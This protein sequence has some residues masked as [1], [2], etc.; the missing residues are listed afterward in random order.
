MPHLAYLLLAFALDKPLFEVLVNT[1]PLGKRVDITYT[2]VN[3]S[4]RTI[5]G[6]EIITTDVETHGSTGVNVIEF[7]KKVKRGARK[8]PIPGVANYPADSLK[9]LQTRVV[10]VTFADGSEWRSTLPEKP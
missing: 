4:R 10:R 1:K 2:L 8:I 3:H 9:S 7:D 6:V 5:Q